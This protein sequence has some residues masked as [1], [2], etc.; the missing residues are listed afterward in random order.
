MAGRP[1]S[2]P[3]LLLCCA[4]KQPGSAAPGV[5]TSPPRLS[6]PSGT[7]GQVGESVGAR[8]APLSVP[9]GHLADAPGPLPQI[10]RDPYVVLRD[11]PAVAEGNLR[12]RQ[13]GSAPLWLVTRVRCVKCVTHKRVGTERDLVASE[14]REGGSSRGQSR[15]RV[16]RRVCPLL[17]ISGP[18]AAPQTRAG[19]EA[20]GSWL[21]STALL[22]SASAPGRVPVVAGRPRG[23]SPVWSGIRPVA[24]GKSVSRK[25]GTVPSGSPHCARR[26]HPG[27]GPHASHTESEAGTCSRSCL[28]G[29]RQGRSLFP[30]G[31]PRDL[32]LLRFMRF[33]RSK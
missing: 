24:R 25:G 23:S 19:S 32:T 10:L 21:S 27:A 16:C 9:L 15:A 11:Q 3:V 20:A 2:D 7:G 8:A 26:P 17:P 4:Q 12:G 31:K 14:G 28:E 33:S 1:S 22:P 30:G 5:W 29:Q 18:A 6:V 13:D